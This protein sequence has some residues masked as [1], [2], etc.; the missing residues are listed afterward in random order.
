MPAPQPG[1][2]IGDDHAPNQYELVRLVK[3]GGEGDVWQAK[4][5]RQD[6]LTQSSWAVKIVD[7]HRLTTGLDQTP[8]AVL[9]EYYRRA[10]RARQ[11]TAQLSQE[12]P[13]IV[14]PTEVFI[15]AEPHQLGEPPSGRSVYVISP[16]VDGDDLNAWS[17][18]KP[19]SFEETCHVLAEL[20]AIIDGMARE[21]AVHRDI[22]PGNVMADQAGRVRLID[23]TYVRP[24]NSAAGTVR[25]LTYGYNAPESARG[26]FGTAGDRYSFGAIAHFL[27]SR[28][29]PAASDAVADSQVWLARAGYSRAVAAHVAALLNPNP[30]AR[31]RSLTEWTA[32]LKALGHREAA[33][34]R[35]LTFAMAVDGTATPLV[36]AATAAGVFEARLGAGLAWQLA[37]DPG[38][39]A[40][41]A[42]LAMVTDGSGERVTFAATGDGHVWRGRSGEWA[43]LGPAVAGSGLAAVRDPYGVA[44][45][46]TIA[47]EDHELL[48]LTVSPDGG[49]RRIETG[50]PAQR[51][52][53]AA[54][55]GGGSPLV[56]VLSA[57]G[58]LL[59]IDVKGPTRV[60][61]HGA[62]SA[63]ACADRRGELRCY[64]I[65]AGQDTLDWYERVGADWDLV[66]TV[67]MPGPATAVACAGHREGIGVA[68]A[69]PGGIH[70]ATHGDTDFGPWA[71][72][73]PKSASHVALAV[74]ARW[75]LQ[76]AALVD[77]QVAVAEEDFTGNWQRRTRF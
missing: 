56:L 4:T 3:S 41:V 59:C 33:A 77:N 44:T 37:R 62:I 10:R 1:D 55:D 13:G 65:G 69:G 31:P 60:S 70:A 47:H 49:S 53:A 11:E 2:R 22:S 24:P 6:A 72:L 15:G 32:R 76:L 39:P 9:E 73:T 75:R 16:W 28:R 45:G 5:F 30:G 66:E 36:S 61:R 35:Y 34:E 7:P 29:E 51:V 54:A 68:I 50:H 21:D 43:S 46:Y 26:D 40:G 27:L 14:G 67:K 52:L 64:R 8:G 20:A 48:V 17:A 42:D 19:R 71:E 18:R 57:S 23:L 12:V 58:E 38:S 74:G 63:A 25:V